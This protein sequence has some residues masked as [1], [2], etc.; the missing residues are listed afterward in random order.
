M[1]RTHAILLA[2]LFALVTSACRRNTETET[3]ASA[4]EAPPAPSAPP[5]DSAPEPTAQRVQEPLLWEISSPKGK[6]YLFGTMHLGV[7]ADDLPAVVWDKIREAK[8]FVMEADVTD[9]AALTGMMQKAQLP[10][11]KSL[12]TELGPEL[13]PKTVAAAQ[14]P[15]SMLARFKP[16]FVVVTI[17]AQLMPKTQPMDSALQ[18]RAKEERDALAYLESWQ[19]Q[20]QML[21]DGIGLDVL[22]DTVTRL[23]DEKKMAQS[24]H[25]AYVKGDAAALEK[26]AFDP[27]E[28]KRHPK[29][30]DMLFFQR[31]DRWI[32]LLEKHMDAGTTFIAVGAAHLLGE[33]GLVALLQKKGRTARRV[34]AAK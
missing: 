11:D 32:P 28:M 3:I 12:E 22:K 8:T 5:A 29:L 7:A 34:T 21:E 33:R 27:A 17:T 20:V 13:W 31:N 10:A 24:M 30:Y 14:L 4:T 9:P 23:D 18:A 25:G 15:E 6:S 19:E 1:T 26:T 2:L 16:W